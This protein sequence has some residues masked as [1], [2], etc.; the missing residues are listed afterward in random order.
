MGQ[1]NMLDNIEVFLTR[2]NPLKSVGTSAFR[3]FWDAN[4]LQANNNSSK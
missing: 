4:V 1:V 3:I 2:P